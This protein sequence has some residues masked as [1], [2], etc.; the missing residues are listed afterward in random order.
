MTWTCD[1]GGENPDRIKRCKNCDGVRPLPRGSGA[2]AQQYTCKKC[3]H[4]GWWHPARELRDGDMMPVWVRPRDGAPDYIAGWYHPHCRP[5]LG[6]LQRQVERVAMQSDDPLISASR[7][8]RG[9]T[10][11]DVHD[12]LG[13]V[14]DRIRAVAKPL[15]YDPGLMQADG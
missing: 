3:G 9:A 7:H 2:T 4:D 13:A 12:L 5:V 8:M 6:E 11:E 14:M 15:P 10:V 1:C